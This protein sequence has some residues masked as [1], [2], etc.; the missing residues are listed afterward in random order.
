[1]VRAGQFVV[2][3]ILAFSVPAS[4]QAS[5]PAAP[6]SAPAAG[7]PGA[8]PAL[9]V[10]AAVDAYL[11]KMPPTER[12]HSDSYF[13][14]G[15]WLILWDFLYAVVVMWLLLHFRWSARMRDLAERLT[16]FRPLQTAL[17]WI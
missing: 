9:D 13:E 17:Y 12:A 11:A 4:G 6:T 10:R 2:L 16:R 1:M 7:Q 8:G 5:P 15:Y 14:G 3:T